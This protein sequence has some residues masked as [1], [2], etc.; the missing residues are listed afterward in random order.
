MVD[1][2]K[3]ERATKKNNTKPAPPGHRHLEGSE[4][5]P[6][7]GARRLQNADPDQTVNVTLCI[8]RRLE[9][10]SLPDQDHWM[11]TLPGHR[12]FLSKK[13]FTAQYGAAQSDLDKVTEFARNS[14][15][16][17]VWTDIA[18]RVVIV[19]GTV[20]QMNKVFHADLGLY[21][22]GKEKYRGREGFISLPNEVA[23][24]VEGVFGLDNR[25][26]ARRASN[27]SPAN[28]LTPLQ[29]AKYYN[30]PAGNAASQT[31]G[32]FEFSDPVAGDAGYVPSDVSDYFT[33]NKGIGPGLSSPTLTDVPINGAANSPGTE[34][35]FEVLI[36]ICVAGAVAQQAS[37]NVYFTTW[38]ENGWVLAIKEA[39]HPTKGETSPSALS[40][41]WGWGEFETA[42][43]VSWTQMA[44]NQVSAM[45]Q[46]AAAAGI[47][48][49]VASGDYGSDCELGDGKA[50]VFYPASDPWI[51]SCGGTEIGS[52]SGSYAEVTWP[53]TGG[54]ISAA[55]PLPAWQAD[56]DVPVSVNSGHAA[57]R[58]I[59]DIAGFANGY[60]V[61]QGGTTQGPFP[62]TSETA[63]LYAGLIALLNENLGQP[64]GYLNPT[65]YALAADPGVTGVFRDINDGTSNAQNGAPGYKS[66]PGWDACTGLGVLDGGNLLIELQAIY[67]KACTLTTDR[68]HY[69]QDEIDALRTQPGGAV[70]R[71]AFFAI[72][73]GFTPTQLGIT[74]ATSLAA[75][76]VVAFLPAAGVTN[77]CSSLVSDDPSF[78]PQVQ[79]FRFGYDVNFGADD[80]AFTAFAGL[81]EIVTLSTTFQGLTSSAQVTFMKQPDPYINQGAQTWWLSSDIRLIQVATGDQSFG[82][83]MGD[84]PFDF[85]RNVT[86][87]LEASQGAGFDANTQE[88]TEVISVAPTTKRSGHTVNVYNFAIARV[89]YQALTSPADNVRVFFRLFAAN[90]TATDFQPTT[91]YRRF[92]AY[93]PNYPVPLVDYDQGVVPALGISAGEYVSVP[94]LG[95]ARADPTQAGAPNTL[96]AKQTVDSFNVRNLAAT[97]GPVHDTFYGCYLDINLPYPPATQAPALPAMPPANNNDGPWPNLALESVRESFIVNDH[98]C[99]IAEIA[100]DPDPIDSGTAPF[101]SDKFAQRNISWSA[102]ANPGVPSSRQ[103]MEPFEV[104]PTP[105]LASTPDE[106]MIDWTNV[107]L[108]QLAEFYLPAVDADAVLQVAAKLYGSHRLTRVDANT[109]GCLTGGVTYIPL[110]IGSVDGANFVGLLSVNMPYGITK[111]ELYTVIVRQLTSATGT[112]AG[113]TPPPPPPPRIAVQ[114]SPASYAPDTIQ[115]RRVLGTFQT[116]IPVST[117]ELLLPKEEQRLSIFRWIG[118]SMPPQ[119]R[120]YPVFQRY[121]TGIAGRVSGFGGDPTKI[122]GSP[123]GDGKQPPVG[124]NRCEEE[125][126]CYTTFSGKIIGLIFDRFGDFKGFELDTECG[127][128]TFESR[129]KEMQILA[130]RV[131]QERLDITVRVKRAELHRP[132]S[133]VVR[134]PTASYGV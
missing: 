42:D 5:R 128:L 54:G 103:A 1:P 58:G 98:Q 29:V 102:V 68:D 30:F 115:W 125:L 49:F 93:T 48:I 92:A 76:P 41:S 23:D 43:N 64:V 13:E 126:D 94:C 117:K 86:A 74:G 8:R 104:R 34:N 39:V 80:S 31:I 53:D 57:G 72:V 75:A 52:E 96:P 101:N 112:V 114:P 36:D 95:E 110:P 40:I 21:E 37:I 20:A 38:D 87:A 71:G 122:M 4:R 113:S 70:V 77:K 47:S 7:V 15:L 35:D 3:S 119:R 62:G 63:P 127:D 59:P 67:T 130:E 56:A 51:T 116:N 22:R 44:M 129:E 16:A 82:V 24:L 134:P 83:T 106:L 89:H 6:A 99:L 18:Q 12:K 65:L 109:I 32:V 60:S 108:G 9:A 88:D 79:R 107:P 45:F 111:G 120:W 26:M 19:S 124:H 78:G 66:G 55:F 85:L 132:L 131:W 81:T 69:G 97:G 84:D 50:H 100:F 123:T 17:V 14:G 133:I 10:P 73:D 33:T 28:S 27:F 2:K 61:V 105:A 91:T 90:S 11:K 25:K 121:L 46:E 118:K